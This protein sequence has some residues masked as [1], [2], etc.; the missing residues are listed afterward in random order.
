M[1]MSDYKRAI[2]AK[3][4]TDLLLVPGALAFIYDNEG[5]L[6]LQKRGDG[7]LWGIPGGE[8]DPGESPADAVVREVWEEMGV[9]VEPEQLAAVFGGP[10]WTHSYPNGDR[11]SAIDIVFACRITSGEP[12]PDGVEVLAVRYFT[13]E[14]VTA[15]SLSKSDRRVLEAAFQPHESVAFNPVTWQPP[16]DG[17]RKNG[18]SPHVRDLREKVGTDLILSVGA[19]AIITNERGEVL[20]QRRGDTGRWGINGG[21]VDPDESPADAVVREVWEETGLRVRPERIAG[22][23]GGKEFYLTY[24]NG[25][26]V[27]ITSILFECRVIGGE[28]DADGKET[29]ELRYFKAQDIINNPDVPERMR[30]RVKHHAEPRQHAYFDPPIWRPD[31]S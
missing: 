19:A 28:M 26:Q 21:G 9:L 1:P 16:A 8:I 20:L 10:D 14:E 5:R 6:L 23:Y 30:V 13:A 11:E 15:L 27:A 18:I 12:Q 25:D 22:V 3:I 7:D 31:L 17:V 4:G 29:L 24:P 2:R